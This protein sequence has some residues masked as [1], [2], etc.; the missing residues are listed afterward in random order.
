ME[1]V[2]LVEKFQSFSYRISFLGLLLK[3][4]DDMFFANIQIKIEGEV[5]T[6]GSP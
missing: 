3:L 1:D 5:L 2:N 6:E 4:V